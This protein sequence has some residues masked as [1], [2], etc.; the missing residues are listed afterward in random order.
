MEGGGIYSAS[1]SR[2]GP[3]YKHNAKLWASPWAE[4]NVKLDDGF[5]LTQAASVHEMR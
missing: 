5:Y 2:S 1:K 4:G 3:L